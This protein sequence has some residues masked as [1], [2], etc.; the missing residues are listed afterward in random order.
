MQVVCYGIVDRGYLSLSLFKPVSERSEHPCG[1][2][3]EAILAVSSC[4]PV[5]ACDTVVVGWLRIFPFFLRLSRQVFC[6]TKLFKPP[7]QPNR[8]VVVAKNMYYLECAGCR[9]RT[10][11]F[12][13]RQH[14][15]VQNE[16][17]AA[18][19]GG[20]SSCGIMHVT[21][22]LCT[23]TLLPSTLYRVHLMLRPS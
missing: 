2:T 20:L 4:Y 6:R 14:L 17:F 9:Y 21:L 7:L 15:S 5:I 8:Q 19:G 16:C 1:H 23:C 18:S 12:S 22:L 11:S 10:S 13:C 3:G